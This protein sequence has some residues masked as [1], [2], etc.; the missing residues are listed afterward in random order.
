MEC[1]GEES[2]ER[3]EPSRPRQTN[4]KADRA[5]SRTGQELAQ[6]H[7]IGICAFAQPLSPRHQLVPE[8][9]QMCA[10]S[11]EGGEPQ[12]QECEE[13]PGDA[14]LRLLRARIHSRDLVGWGIL[15]SDSVHRERNGFES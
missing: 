15:S 5:G 9:A 11:N 3:A 8:I 12:L 13:Y 10:G 14:S 1:E 7:Q 6:C 4:S 2:C